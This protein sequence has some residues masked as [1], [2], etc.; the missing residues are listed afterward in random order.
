LDIKGVSQKSIKKLYESNLLKSP[1][2]FYYLHQKKEELLKLEGF[3]EKKVNNIL[4]SIEESK[5]KSFANLLTALGIP[6]LSSVKTKKL[7]I[8]YPSFSRFLAAVKNE[9]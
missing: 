2:D 7:T 1:A 6:L 5:K 3:Q 9:E 4:D 8:F